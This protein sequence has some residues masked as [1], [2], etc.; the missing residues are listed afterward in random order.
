MHYYTQIGKQ[1]RD[2]P[3][4]VHWALGGTHRQHQVS[5]TV[6]TESAPTTGQHYCNSKNGLLEDHT[7]MQ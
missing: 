2:S 5:L 6:G 7:C 4:Y 3:H 1:T